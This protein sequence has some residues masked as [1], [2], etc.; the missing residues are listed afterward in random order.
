MDVCAPA[1]ICAEQRT[2]TREC[3]VVL[4]PELLRHER[5]RVVLPFTDVTT[6]EQLV[7]VVVADDEP[8]TAGRELVSLEPLP[9]RARIALGEVVVRDPHFLLGDPLATLVDLREAVGRVAALRV[10]LHELLELVERLLRQRLVLLDGLHLVVVA[11][12]EAVLD[13]VC[14]LVPGKER[15]EAFELLYR[16]VEL[17]LAIVRLADVEPRLRRV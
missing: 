13:E 16:F 1:V 5:L 11:H 14:D 7:E 9:R 8:L 6:D 4:P 10:F 12:R 3:R 17:G 15:Q 2:M